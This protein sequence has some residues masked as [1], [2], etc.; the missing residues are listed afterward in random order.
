MVFNGR[1]FFSCCVADPC[2][3]ITRTAQVACAY[4]QCKLVPDSEQAD[5]IDVLRH[6]TCC[7]Q[8]RGLEYTASVSV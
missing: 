2:S 3:A 5:A 1:L 8:R 4:K 6:A 7:E